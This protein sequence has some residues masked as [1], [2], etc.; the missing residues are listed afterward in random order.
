MEDWSRAS[1]FVVFAGI[2]DAYLWGFDVD[3]RWKLR[4]GNPANGTLAILPMRPRGRRAT[5]GDAVWIADCLAFDHDA[6]VGLIPSASNSRRTYPSRPVIPIPGLTA[7]DWYFRDLA[8]AFEA[9][10]EIRFGASYSVRYDSDEDRA[11]GTDFSSRFAGRE[12]LVS[13]YAMASRQADPM[14]EFLCLYRVL[15]AADGATGTTF[16]TAHLDDL[17]DRDFGVLPVIPHGQPGDWRNAFEV[18]RRRAR[19]KLRR[20]RVGMSANSEVAAYLY[21][22]RNSLAHGKQ[23]VRTGDFGSQVEEV[24]SA[25]PIVKLLARVAVEG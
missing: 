6:P 1:W 15:E 18:Y 21:R 7:P 10:A 11:P 19:Q 2:A 22:L 14:S 12:D 4:H 23:N 8:R 13:L 3:G 25:L 9:A 5:L 20:L 16:A 24:A 17:N